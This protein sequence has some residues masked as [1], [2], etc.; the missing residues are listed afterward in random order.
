M[1]AT[2][3]RVPGNADGP[4]EGESVRFTLV[5]DGV[6]RAAFALRWRGTLVAYV[7]TCRHLSLPLDGGD[8]R[9]LDPGLD[10]L[11]CVHHAACYRPDTGVCIAGP[12]RGARLT[13]LALEQRADGLWCTGRAPRAEGAAG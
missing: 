13:A 2:A 4:R 8:G 1:N 7:N 11:V 9:F 5:L 12:C 6:S 3:V 10:A